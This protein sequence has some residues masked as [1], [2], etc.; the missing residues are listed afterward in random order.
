MCLVASDAG[1]DMQMEKVLAQHN[2]EA[3]MS[4]RV[5]EINASHGLI[6]ALAAKAASGSGG[7]DLEDAA[8]LLLDQARILE[9]DPLADAPDFARRMATMMAKAFG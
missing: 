9:G 2:P 3:A 4:Q 8:L 7:S 1:L 6:K 5:L